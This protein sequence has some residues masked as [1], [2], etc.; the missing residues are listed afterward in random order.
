MLWLGLWK[1]LTSPPVVGGFWEKLGLAMCAPPPPGVDTAELLVGMS[2]LL[3]LT[4][5]ALVT[6]FIR[7]VISVALLSNWPPSLLKPF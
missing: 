2:P 6:I 1:F 5:P 4:A 7:W 3:L